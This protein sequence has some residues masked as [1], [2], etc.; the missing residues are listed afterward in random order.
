MAPVAQPATELTPRS[1]GARQYQACMALARQDPKAAHESAL[2]WRQ[3]GGGSPATH[4]IAVALLGLGQHHLSGQML[5]ELAERTATSRVTLKA[6][7]LSQAANAWLI[8]GQA[9]RSEKLLSEALSLTPRNV[10]IL[11]DRSVARATLE[12]YFDALDDLNEALE[13]MPGRED[14]LTFR[15][16]AWRRVDALDL[17]EKDVAEALERR[18]DYP[19]ALLERGLIHKTKGDIILARADWLR[20]LD[21]AVE[22]P[23][24]EAARRNLQS[25]NEKK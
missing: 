7:L 1:E 21:I 16:S 15:A 23:L 17:A 8:A 14:A 13:I 25:L 9:R 4:C 18:P 19:E 3:N 6:G 11:I 10:D 12:K 5:E 2:A 24:T 22:G 20:V